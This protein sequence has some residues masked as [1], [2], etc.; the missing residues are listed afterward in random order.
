MRKQ[1]KGRETIRETRINQKKLLESKT[2]QGKPKG[3]Q[4]KLGV[5]M[6]EIRKTIRE[7]RRNQVQPKET[8]RNMEENY[9]KLGETKSKPKET[10]RNQEGNQETP[11]KPGD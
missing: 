10:R 3:N 9:E 5:T 4:K 8:M 6:R 7:T 11:Q 2:N 1:E